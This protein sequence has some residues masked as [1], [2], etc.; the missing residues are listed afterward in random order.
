MYDPANLTVPPYLH[1]N[2]ATRKQLADYYAEVTQLDQQVGWL[3]DELETTEQVENTL[4]IFLSEQ[5]SSFPFGGKWSVYDNGIR[6]AAFARWP[7]RVSAASSSDA[8]MQYV[9]LPPTFLEAAGVDPSQ[10]DTGC[11][12]AVGDRGFDGR[13]FLSVLL[14]QSDELRD[15]VFAQHTTVGI[16]GYLEP[17]PMRAVR[18]H[19]YKLIRNLAPRNTYQIGGIHRG[20]LLASWRRDAAEDPL[21]TERIAWLFHRA[22]AELYDLETDPFETTNLADQAEFA[23]VR[24]RLARQLDAWMT[25]QGDRGMRTEQEALSRQ[26]RRRTRSR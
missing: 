25:Q 14:G 10:I 13:S 11:A 22:P 5:G 2:Q 18:D 7:G 23:E 26:P 19:R 15:Y 1:D 24:K 9:D 20:K 17:Y 4:V 6:V 8:L 12:D 21:L 3:L 16:N